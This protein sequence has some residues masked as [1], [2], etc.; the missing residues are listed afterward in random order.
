MHEKR[1]DGILIGRACIDI[2]TQVENFPSED[3]KVAISEWQQVGGGQASTCACLMA[4]LGGKVAFIGRVGTDPEGDKAIK[5]MEQ[6][7]V[8]C[9]FVKRDSNF[10]TPRAFIAINKKNASRTIF[11]EPAF[12]PKLKK[13]DLP[14]S[15]I[16]TSKTVLIDPQEMQVGIEIIDLLKE[17]KCYTILD[18]ERVK[19]GLEIL[20]PKA[21][22]LIVSHSYSEERFPQLS[23]E[24][25]L[26]K[27]YSERMALTAITLGEQGTIAIYENKIITIPSL[28]VNVMDT[29]GAGDNFHAAFALAVARDKTIPHALAYASAV[30]SLTCRG[31]G[32]RSGFPTEKE[33]EEGFSIVAS[34]MEI[35]SI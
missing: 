25:A 6:F 23:V 14:L 2:L 20:I 10:T 35:R 19:E 16:L 13:Q 21:D 11:Y 31:I 12:G 15:E 26:K 8:D 5:E 24:D 33:A 9:S 4:N 28:P 17:N 30:A 1:W 32:G 7:G 18:A 22:A 27:L 3:S 34:K 29:T